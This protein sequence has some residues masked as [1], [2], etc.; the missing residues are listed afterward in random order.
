MLAL[1]S[2]VYSIP[3][4]LVDNSDLICD[5]YMHVIAIYMYVKFFAYMAY[6]CNLEAIFVSGICMPMIHEV[7]VVV[8][9]ALAHVHQCWV[10][11]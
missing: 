3:D 5:M 6:I 4:H 10:Y 7:D 1:L 8:S 9:C 2:S 11:I